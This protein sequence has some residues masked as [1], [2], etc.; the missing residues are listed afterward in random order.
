M[1]WNQLAPKK[2]NGFI[3]SIKAIR[4]SVAL[5]VLYSIEF[6]SLW[7]KIQVVVF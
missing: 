4:E 5:N 1:T 7:K 6:Y 2:E 3:Y